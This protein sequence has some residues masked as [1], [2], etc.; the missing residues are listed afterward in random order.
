MVRPGA[1]VPLVAAVAVFAF[2]ARPAL[3]APQGPTAYWKGDEAAPPPGNVAVDSAGTYDGTY[4]NGATTVGPRPTP[5]P[6]FQFPNDRCMTFAGGAQPAA[7]VSVPDAPALRV[8]G[9]FTVAFWMR[10]TGDVSDWARMVGKGN[11]TQRNFG[12]WEW[13][14]GDGRI[15]FQQY[16]SS[17][18]SVLEL[19][20]TL[21]TR[22]TRGTTS[23]AR[24]RGARPACTST[25]RFT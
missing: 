7:H 13:A 8:T 25:A 20:S 18:G 17:G 2:G 12:V 14:G 4:Q 3:A 15:K 9:D 22:R 1:V 23:P 24:S 10:K 5:A 11:S 6:S 16:N 21:Q 19:D